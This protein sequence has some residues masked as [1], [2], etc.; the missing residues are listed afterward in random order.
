MLTDIESTFIR[1]S[2]PNEK[3]AVDELISYDTEKK[4]IF[5]RFMFL[6]NMNPKHRDCALCVGQAGSG[7]SY[8]MNQYATLYKLLHP[9]NEILFF[10][11]NNAEID[12][13]LTK[14]L[15]R[16]IPMQKFCDSLLG[17]LK[18]MD[19]LKKISFLFQ[20]KILI[21]DDVGSLKSNKKWKGAL[22]T[23]LDHSIENFRK[24]HTSV[25]IIGHTSRLGGD[26]TI[27]REEISHYIVQG[28][29]LQSKNDRIMDASFGFNNDMLDLIF[30]QNDRWLSVLTKERVV[31]YPS[32]I[33]T[34]ESL[35]REAKMK[36]RATQPANTQRKLDF[37][38]T[39]P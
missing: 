10:T 17:V 8:L 2:K 31:I 16:I 36:N 30:Q 34:V 27:I 5:E 7:K 19:E 38:Y 3:D 39:S 22:F 26:G 24:H 25:Y 37:E 12:V 6:P 18:D 23:F 28:N 29:A 1:R 33:V 21:F 20:N 11:L 4:N 13:S 9:K 35:R 14:E 15:Y 32:K